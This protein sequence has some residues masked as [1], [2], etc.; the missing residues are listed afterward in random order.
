M[1]HK[2]QL[3]ATLRDPNTGYEEVIIDVSLPDCPEPETI[4]NPKL[5][6]PSKAKYYEKAYDDN[7]CLIAFPAIHIT[8][9]GFNGY[10]DGEEIN[11]VVILDGSK[12]E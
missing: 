12:E 2:E 6:F 7:L 4:V 5:N 8:C 3:L 11:S 10:R 1:T 9:Y